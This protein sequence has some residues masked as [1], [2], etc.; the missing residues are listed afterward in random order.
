MLS[1]KARHSVRVRVFDCL[2]VILFVR[3]FVYLFVCLFVCS[4]VYW[5][6]CWFVRSFVRL[7]S[8]GLVMWMVFI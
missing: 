6:V 8:L 2:T 5:F 7:H 1:G 3:S 4:F